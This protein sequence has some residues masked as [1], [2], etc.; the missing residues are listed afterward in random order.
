L[1]VHRD[2]INTIAIS[3]DGKLFASG[4]DDGFLLIFNAKSLRELKRFRVPSPVRAIVWHPAQP[5]FVTYGTASGVVS[6]LAHN[7]GS[8]FP[9]TY[10]QFQR[11][12][13]GT[14]HCLAIR[15]DGQFLAVGFHDEVAIV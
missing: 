1:V 5:E 8:Y 10:T 7:A 4:G 15:F 9:R 2:P 3:C 6:T 14:V 12:M 11:S 13:P